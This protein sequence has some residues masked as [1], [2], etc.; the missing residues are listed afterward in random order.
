MKTT[1]YIIKCM[2]VSALTLTVLTGC[3]KDLCYNHDEHALTAK[4]KVSF[5]WDQEWERDYGADW[6]NNWKDEWST[7]Y[8]D[9][10]PEAA[11]GVRVIVYHPDATRLEATLP[12][13]GDIL[14]LVEGYNC[15]LFY[16]NDT[17]YI[18]FDNLDTSASAS[19]S[20]R[21]R[22]RSSFADLHEGERTVNQPDMLYGNYVEDFEAI[23][24]VTAPELPIVMRPLVYTYHIRYEFKSG[25]QYVAKARGALAG[26][27]ESVYMQDGRTS[28]ST[29]TILYD[30]CVIEDYGVEA[31]IMSFG[32]PAFPD[33][34]YQPKS[35]RNA[36]G[37][38]LSL[39][40]MLKNGKLLEYRFDVTDQIE[41][42]PRGGVIIVN[43]IVVSD[44]DGM[45]GSGGFD[46]DLDDWG[47]IIDVPLP[48]E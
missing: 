1:A 24:T 29:A 43:D 47:D 23:R 35:R 12:V 42:Q 27:A 2:A 5:E 19:A 28:E 31:T 41:L 20:T 4:A 15:I 21:T 25:L 32:K 46:V 37:Y 38:K 26:M 11:G 8:D 16:N 6:P 18:T 30:N 3:R 13:E 44:E 48:L 10:R 14:P 40:V 45:E 36:Q 39:E 22:T 9:L 17:E 7:A 34:Y 33:E